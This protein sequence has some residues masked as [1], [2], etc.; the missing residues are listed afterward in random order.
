MNP[1]PRR[2]AVR[3]GFDMT[4]KITE[5]LKNAVLKMDSEIASDTS[6]EIVLNNLDVADA[7]VNGLNAG[8]REVAQSYDRREIYLPQVL[9]SANTFYIAFDILPPYLSV[10]EYRP[11][12]KLIIG[13]LKGHSRHRQE[14]DQ[15]DDR[16]PRLQLYRSGKRCTDR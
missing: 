6:L 13:W 1:K 11:G 7:V 8:M 9:A 10:D 15:G 2:F 4:S 5:R 3:S 12:K 14:S 16:G